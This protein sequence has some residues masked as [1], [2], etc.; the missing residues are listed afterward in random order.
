MNYINQAP[1]ELKAQSAG[2]KKG[3]PD[4]RSVANSGHYYIEPKYD[5]VHG[6]AIIGQAGGEM[7]S[8]DNKKYLS[9]NHILKALHAMA[10]P[11][12]VYFGEVY[13]FDTPFKE[14]S[15]AARRHSDQP[16]LLFVVYDVIT[17]E[18]FK[19]G[20]STATYEQRR[21]AL[22]ELRN[23]YE[24]PIGWPII[25]GAYHPAFGIDPDAYSAELKAKGGYDGGMLKDAY[26]GWK[27]GACKQGEAIKVKP[28]LTLD[29]QVV[30]MVE[31]EGKHSGTMGALTVIYR[32]VTTNVGTGFTD[33]ERSLWWSI[34]HVN[35]QSSLNR[36][37]VEVK[38]MEV[39]DNNTLREPVF[40]AQRHDK[41]TPD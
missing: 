33:A 25:I 23:N 18:E 22:K 6:V 20:N 30:G 13:K 4:L 32:G 27:P 19:A 39:N 11:G 3:H 8:R 29:L 2:F 34:R 14:I 28:Q 15:G 7:L 36:Y 16:D 1:K 12:F 9:C 5:G 21:A 40:I 10:G 35:F 26:A 24:A 31:G 38:C 37:I 41:T 17:E